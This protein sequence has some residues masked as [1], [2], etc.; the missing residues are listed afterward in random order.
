MLAQVEGINLYAVHRTFLAPDGLG[1][2]SV[3]PVEAMLG[4]CSGGAVRLAAS[5]IGP[6]VVCEG[7]ETGLSLIQ[8]MSEPATV[9]AAMSASGM[10]GLRL[11]PEPGRLILGTDGDDAGRRAGQ[12]LALRAAEL[13][14][15]VEILE[16]A[17][18]SDWND[19][20]L[21]GGSPSSGTR[22]CR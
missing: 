6:L 22:L 16:A 3:A 7:I 10:K 5:P 9:W 11:P 4:P 19:F 14:W 21:E 20:L 8:L 12:D 18:G 15:Q 2:S 1:K 17:E 13:S